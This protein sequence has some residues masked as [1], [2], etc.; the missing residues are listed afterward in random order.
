[1]MST[2]GECFTFHQ[3]MDDFR[4]SVLIYSILVI[5][6]QWVGDNERLCAMEPRL[7]LKRPSAHVGLKPGTAISRDQHLTYLLSNDKQIR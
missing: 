1:M 6:G 2:T 7:G 5:S 3:W 4:L